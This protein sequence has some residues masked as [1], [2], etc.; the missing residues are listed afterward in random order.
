MLQ[1]FGLVLLARLA[2]SQIA[3]PLGN[4]FRGDVVFL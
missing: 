4:L 2:V 3:P 1:T